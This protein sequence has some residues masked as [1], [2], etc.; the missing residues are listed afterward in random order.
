QAL[1]RL[2]ELDDAYIEDL[3]VEIIEVRQLAR[4]HEGRMLVWTGEGLAPHA[5]S[6]RVAHDHQPTPTPQP[7][8][9]AQR[10]QL[11]VMFCDLVGSTHLS[12]QLDPEDLREV[13]RAYQ[14]TATEV[15][16]RY[17]GHVAQLLGDGLLVYFGFP[18]AHEDDAQRA[19]YTGLGIITA[20][21]QLNTRLEQE[22]NVWLDVRLGIHTGPVVVGEMGEHG[23]QEHLPLG[24]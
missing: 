7:S 21:E 18:R 16:Q 14:K 12:R 19:V 4:D 8:V 11:T 23:R 10:R 6:Q 22:K 20:M 9:E 3:K 5:A 2:F 24:E 15:L 17:D 13:V 1:K